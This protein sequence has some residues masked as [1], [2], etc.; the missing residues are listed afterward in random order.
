MSEQVKP[1]CIQTACFSLPFYEAGEWRVKEKSPWKH[2]KKTEY[3]SAEEVRDL[4]TYLDRNVQS[5]L[6]VMN[7]LLEIHDDWQITLK[8]DGIWMETETMMYEDILPELEKR[9]I[10]KERYIMYSEYTR[11]WG[12]I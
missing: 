6:E 3:Y 12:M 9:G 8:K 10:A 2:L 5:A 7:A 1:T 11:K 4:V